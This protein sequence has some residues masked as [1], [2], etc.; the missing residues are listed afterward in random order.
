MKYA[1]CCG[2]VDAF[3]CEVNSGLFVLSTGGAGKLGF[4]D[5]GFEV[6]L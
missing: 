4:L 1:F 5:V 3:H 2:L 6:G